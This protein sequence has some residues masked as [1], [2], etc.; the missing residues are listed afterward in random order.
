[1]DDRQRCRHERVRR[2]EHGLAAN[3]RVFES[4][5]RGAGPVPESDRRPGVPGRPRRLELLGQL[6]FGPTF[7]VQRLIPELV[8][9]DPVAMVEA[10]GE[11]VD[12]D[13]AGLHGCA[14]Y[15]L[16]RPASS[17]RSRWRYRAATPRSAAFSASLPGSMPSFCNCAACFS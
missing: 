6:T 15:R 1:M 12:V 10:D 3:A 13:L 4:R 5:E 7:R 16:Q 2:A 17:E 9:P 14:T 8:Q 11:G